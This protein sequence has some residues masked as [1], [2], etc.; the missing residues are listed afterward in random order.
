MGDGGRNG[1]T[2]TRLIRFGSG[3]RKCPGAIKLAPR[4]GAMK[5]REIVDE[6]LKGG[7]PARQARRGFWHDLAK[8]PL[9]E[10]VFPT[11]L[12]VEQPRDNIKFENAGFVRP[13]VCGVLNE[14]KT[15]CKE[16][17]EETLESNK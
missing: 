6:S 9:E 13:C 10:S 7:K 5:S 14:R 1:C 15:S 4:L 16:A 11:G 12:G 3:S 2:K 8:T 17:L